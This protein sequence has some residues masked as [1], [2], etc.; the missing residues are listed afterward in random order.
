VYEHLLI[1]YG[2]ENAN[3]A[4]INRFITGGHFYEDAINAWAEGSDIQ[5]RLSHNGDWHDYQEVSGRPPYFNAPGV[6]WRR[7]PRTDTI[8]YTNALYF[9]GIKYWVEAVM[10][11][12][13][14]LDLRQD[15]EFVRCIGDWHCVEVEK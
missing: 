15:K 4:N 9:N 6:E 5:Y 11:D 1:Q 10:A 3:D 12:E 13:F 2:E 8:W 7:K 14:S